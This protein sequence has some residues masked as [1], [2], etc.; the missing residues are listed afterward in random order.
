MRTRLGRLTM[1]A[2]LAGVVGMAMAVPASAQESDACPRGGV[3]P[4]ISNISFSPS[5][6][7]VTAAGDIEM[8]KVNLRFTVSRGWTETDPT[9]VI[10]DLLGRPVAF[11][12]LIERGG[13]GLP[14]GDYERPFGVWP[15][16]DRDP[17]GVFAVSRI[18]G[19]LRPNTTYVLIM[20]ADWFTPNPRPFDP[21]K[22]FAHKV[23]RT[24]AKGA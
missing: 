24:G 11:G 14:C 5:R 20:W 3:K 19:G 2:V 22:V 17:R 12:G 9:V 10:V 15:Y 8:A 13:G 16:D 4:R 18:R 7:P 21:L 1:C 23:F 6:V